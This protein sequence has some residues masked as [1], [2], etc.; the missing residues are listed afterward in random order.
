MKAMRKI[1]VA[2]LL[3]CSLSIAQDHPWHWIKVSNASPRWYT[4]EGDAEIAIHGDQF[5]A[6]LFREDSSQGIILKGTI[7][8]NKII[9]KETVLN[10]DF[11]GST[12][13]G[14][15]QH[16]I[17][18]ETAGTIGAESITLTDGWGMIGLT[19]SIPK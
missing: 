11:S 16:K 18:E 5:T 19:R 2:L 4:Q 10:S 3:L 9:V 6:T 8:Q 7:R 12:Y 13:H 1:I 17:W 14:T 15:F